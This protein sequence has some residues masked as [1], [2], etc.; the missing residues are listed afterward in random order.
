MLHRSLLL[1]VVTAAAAGALEA[2]QA[3]QAPKVE[4]AFDVVS[5]RRNS[6][7][8]MNASLRPDGS[9]ALVSVT[10]GLLVTI[11]YPTIP[12]S[13]IIG[14]PDWARS[15][16]ER[17]DVM[18]TVVR[19]R[20]NPTEAQRQGMLRGLLAERFRF[21]ARI[22]TREQP[23][24][25][26]VLARGDSRLGP[27]LKPS[28]CDPDATALTAAAA[29]GSPRPCSF[30]FATTVATGSQKLEGDITMAVLASMLRTRAGRPVVE[31]TGLSGTYRVVMEFMPVQ[32][33]PTTSDASGP[34][35]LFTAI[36]EQLGLRLESTRAPADALVIERMERPTEN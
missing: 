34:P 13:A 20:A 28:D 17:Y 9:L 36:Q 3:S 19:D 6:G 18:A 8:P 35:L 15:D 12:A 4:P 11:A 21:V 16:S 26:L 10:A 23:A 2:R 27:G 7:A 5:I 32:A 30:G 25:A 24:Y 1:T 29:P 31:K 22:E 33:L 14:M